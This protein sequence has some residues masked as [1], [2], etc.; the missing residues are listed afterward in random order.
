[1]RIAFF[2]EGH[3]GFESLFGGLSS[4]LLNRGDCV[5]ACYD[6]DSE[7]SDKRVELNRCS[8]TFFELEKVGSFQPDRVVIFNSRDGSAL[9][10]SRY[11]QHRYGDKVLHDELGWLPQRGHIY[12]DKKG[13]GGWSQICD[14]NCQESYDIDSIKKLSELYP[15]RDVPAG[16]PKNFILVPLQLQ[17]DTTILYDS[18]YIKTMYSLVGFVVNQFPDFPI[19]VRKHPKDTTSHTLRGVTYITEGPSTIE[20]A[21]HA[22]VIIGINST[23]LIESLVYN[24]PVL[25]LGKNVAV[26][27]GVF[28]DGPEAFAYPRKVLEWKPNQNDVNRTLSFLMSR[29]FLASSPPPHVISEF[30]DVKGYRQI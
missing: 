4:V 30:F 27:R 25:A 24:K 10:V 23:T 29:Q 8:W 17:N 2:T 28:Y 22:R 13:C 9:A 11:L 16:L 20:L 3:L 26:G 19:V 18:P 12:L 15:K 7:P 21:A 6:G 5:M 1:M 14:Q